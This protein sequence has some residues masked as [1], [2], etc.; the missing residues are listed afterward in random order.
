MRRDLIPSWW[1]T[2]LKEMKVA[3]FNARATEISVTPSSA[4][5]A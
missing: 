3:T 5:D 2:P 1:A 4:R